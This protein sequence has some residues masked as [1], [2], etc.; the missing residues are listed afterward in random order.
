MKEL[1]NSE[2]IIEENYTN[3]GLKHTQLAKSTQIHFENKL[4]LTRGKTN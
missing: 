4:T 3:W 1:A 2:K